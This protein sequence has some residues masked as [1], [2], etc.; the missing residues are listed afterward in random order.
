M[1]VLVLNG[2]NLNML[3]Y[4]DHKIYG[5]FSLEDIENALKATCAE[6]NTILDFR[7]SNHEGEIIESIQELV[8]NKKNYLGLIINAAAYTH[9]SIAIA[10]ALEMVDLPIYEVH[11]SDVQNREDFR[12]I[13][14]ISKYATEVI[15]GKSLNGYIEAL[16]NIHTLQTKCLT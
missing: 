3:G 11:L 9:T 8:L 10:D 7:Q 4:R 6:Q 13:S 12:K 5:S 1:K 2:P 14:Y 15:S 16:K